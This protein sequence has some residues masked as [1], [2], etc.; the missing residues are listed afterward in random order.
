MNTSIPKIGERL[1]EVV[2]GI[3]PAVLYPWMVKRNPMPRKAIPG[4]I[5]SEI[6]AIAARRA[7]GTPLQ[8]RVSPACNSD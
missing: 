5:V 7:S 2:F 1:Y 3:E 4:V 8:T 6:A